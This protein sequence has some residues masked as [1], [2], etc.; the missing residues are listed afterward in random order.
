MKQIKTISIKMTF[1][2]SMSVMIM[3]LENGNEKG[4]KIAREECM[5]MAK[6]LDRLASV[7][8]TTK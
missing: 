3:T 5:K 8:G 7:H 1:A 2:Y 4:K 6:E